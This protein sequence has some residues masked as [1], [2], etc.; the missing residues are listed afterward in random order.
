VDVGAKHVH[1]SATIRPKRLMEDV[2]SALRKILA[3]P[4]STWTT[5]ACPKP[6][7]RLTPDASEKAELDQEELTALMRSYGNLTPVQ[8]TARLWG[9]KVKAPEKLT[10]GERAIVARPVDANKLRETLVQ[11]E[12]AKSFVKYVIDCKVLRMD[13]FMNL[14]KLVAVRLNPDGTRA[15]MPFVAAT[16]GLMIESTFIL[17][18]NTGLGKTA[19]A[20][21]MC[22]LFCE[23]KGV[24]YFIES[25]TVDSLRTVYVNGFFR[26]HVPVLLDEWKPTGDKYSG[27]DGIDMLKCLNTVGDAATIKC[28]YSDIRFQDDQPKVQSCNCTSLDDWCRCL[29]EVDDVDKNAVLRRCLFVEITESLVPAALRKEFL[30]Q[31]RESCFSEMSLAAVAQGCDPASEPFETDLCFK[32]MTNVKGVWKV[33]PTSDVMSLLSSSASSS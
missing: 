11:E 13:Q 7:V 23:A 6:V 4:G 20:R 27:K 28:R 31:R 14:D 25:N 3:G 22:K 2:G 8:W 15:Y 19:L 1:A 32:P 10:V 24:A 9:L 18:G 30:G 26:K 12:N 17:L 29:G 16:R 21:A 33:P 5:M